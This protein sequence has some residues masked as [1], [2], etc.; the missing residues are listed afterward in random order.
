[1]LVLQ[2]CMTMLQVNSL[3]GCDGVLFVDTSSR[4]LLGLPFRSIPLRSGPSRSVPFVPFRSPAGPI[5]L[6]P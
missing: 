2:A 4:L 1:M 5:R 6:Q 3:A